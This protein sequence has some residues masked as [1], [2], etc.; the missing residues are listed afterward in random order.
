MTTIFYKNRI[1]F[2]FIF[3]P[4]GAPHVRYLLPSWRLSMRQWTMLRSSLCPVT[5]PRRKCSPTW[6]SLT[7]SGWLS[8][9]HLTSLEPWTK[10]TGWRGS[11]PSWSS[12]RMALW[13]PRRA[14]L[15]SRV[16][17]PDRLL[18]IGQ[19]KTRRQIKKQRN[20]SISINLFYFYFENIHWTKSRSKW[21][22]KMVFRSQYL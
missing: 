21:R 20:Q 19:D 2:C 12:S 10:S 11:P 22:D 14:A 13:S 18:S 1:L 8:S 3:L 15:M 9:M 4:T 7:G 6:R 5:S 17:S 16:S